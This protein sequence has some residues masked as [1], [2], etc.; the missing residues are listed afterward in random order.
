[1]DAAA[2]HV[3]GFEF[4]PRCML[5]GLFVAFQHQEIILDQPLVGFE[6]QDQH[7]Q[8]FGRRIAHA[9]D[10]TA[11]LDRQGQAIGTVIVVVRLEAVFGQQ[12]LQRLFLLFFHVGRQ[13]RFRKNRQIDMG[14][15]CLFLV[16]HCGRT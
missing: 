11:F 10:K 15:A 14:D 16:G 13:G 6:G 12:V 9:D 4:F 5:A 8:F 7:I 2:A 1:M 3:D